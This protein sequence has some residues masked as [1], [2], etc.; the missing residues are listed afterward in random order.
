MVTK[1]TVTPPANSS[2][3]ARAKGTAKRFSVCLRPGETK[4]QTWKATTG[5]AI[6]SP[7]TR[8]R[9]MRMPMPSSG[10]CASSPQ[11][12]PAAVVMR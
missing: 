4:R 7:R 5:M 10:L 2:V 3:L 8:E 12:W 11:P 6:S 9:R 1:A